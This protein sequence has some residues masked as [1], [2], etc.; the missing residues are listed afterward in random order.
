MYGTAKKLETPAAPE[1]EPEAAPEA[2]PAAS[3]SGVRLS[4]WQSFVKR[5][6]VPKRVVILPQHF[7]SCNTVVADKQVRTFTEKYTKYNVYVD[8][9]FLGGCAGLPFGLMRVPLGILQTL[10]DVQAMDF[11]PVPFRAPLECIPPF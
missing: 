3:A 4:G 5:H 1:A 2:E 10:Q 6:G 11:P 7:H 9:A 8:Y